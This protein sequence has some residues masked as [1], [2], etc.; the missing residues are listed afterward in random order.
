MRVWVG[1]CVCVCVCV[2]YFARARAGACVRVRVRACVCV[3]VC[4]SAGSIHHVMCYFPAKSWPKYS[5]I[6]T[7]HDVLEP[8]KQGL[9]ASRDV[10]ISGQSCGVRSCRGFS[11][12]VTD[13]GCPC[14]VFVGVLF[15]VLYVC[16]SVFSLFSVCEGECVHVW[17]LRSSVCTLRVPQIAPC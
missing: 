2:R 14:S 9:S 6:I 1:V 3:C 15:C 5:K 4:S 17:C 16:K 10:I 8:L 13:A 11:H 7:S 12:W